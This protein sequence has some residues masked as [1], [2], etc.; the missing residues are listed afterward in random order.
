MMSALRI[1]RLALPHMKKQQWGRIIN[2][3]SYS[4]KTPVSGLFI[5]NTIRLGVL[6]WAKALSDEVA[7]DGIHVQLDSGMVVKVNA[8]ALRLARSKRS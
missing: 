1:S 6:G 7:K 2:I 3:S 5:S 8:D 4:V